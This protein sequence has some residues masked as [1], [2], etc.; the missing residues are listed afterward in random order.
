MNNFFN[1]HFLSVAF[2]NTTGSDHMIATEYSTFS[3]VGSSIEGAYKTPV[4]CL[5]ILNYISRSKLYLPE[6]CIHK[7]SRDCKQ[8]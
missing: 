6:N 1:D 4:N 3:G 5:I 7:L 2:L 8:S